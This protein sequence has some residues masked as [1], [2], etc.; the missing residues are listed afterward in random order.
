MT[1][2][3]WFAVGLALIFI[4]WGL[5]PLFSRSAQA[6]HPHGEAKHRIAGALESIAAAQWKQ[7]YWRKRQALALEAACCDCE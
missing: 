2:V 1:K 4:G 5:E 3:H 6:R 7:V